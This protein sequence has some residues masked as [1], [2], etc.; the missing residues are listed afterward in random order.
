M[1]VSVRV[2]KNVRVYLPFWVAIPLWLLVA[3][4]NVAVYTVYAAGWLLVQGTRVV[5]AGFIAVGD[6]REERRY[7]APAASSG[8][9]AVTAAEA[10][11]WS[12]PV[13]NVRRTWRRLDFDLADPDRPS[14]GT[15][16]MSARVSR[17]GGRVSVPWG[18][19]S[20]PLAGLQ[21]GDVVGLV[22]TE[23]GQVEHAS[24]VQRAD[25]SAP[26]HAGAAAPAVDAPAPPRDGG[27]AQETSGS[28]AFDAAY[29]QRPAWPQVKIDRRSGQPWQ[30]DWARWVL[31]LALPTMIVGAAIYDLGPV[32]KGFGSVLIDAPVFAV[33]AAVIALLARWWRKWRAS[34]TYAA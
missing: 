22:I 24:I 13:R 28:P 14:P 16:N 33:L 23:S 3:A 17:A 21:D 6:R 29:I 26:T 11:E 32:G 5:G 18:V 7:I 8:S 34:K 2:S 1:G 31:I 4:C 12:G 9:R 20:K 19:G 25:G 30:R 27:S 10:D 15:F